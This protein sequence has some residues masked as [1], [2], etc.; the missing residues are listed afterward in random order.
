MAPAGQLWST[1]AD[2]CRFGCFLADPAE[3][4]LS[5][6]S[7]EEMAT[8]ATLE[9]DAWGDGQGHGLQLWRNGERLYAG[10]GGS[11]P[12]F[13]AG[14]VVHRPSRTAATVMA[15]RW[16]GVRGWGLALELLDHV[17]DGLPAPAAPWSAAPAPPPFADLLGHWWWRGVAH[18]VVARDGMLALA[19]VGDDPR[20][21]TLFRQTGPDSYEGT[22]GQDLGEALTV[23]RDAGGTA[24]ALVA[25]G[26]LYTRDP[27]DPRTV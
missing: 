6:A 17:L 12:G 15:N 19:R 11:M 3:E 16:Q 4:V 27:D 18:D 2:L 13:I 9:P 24:T 7:A 10:H 23:Q 21:A 22:N 14:L 25:G 8:P 26:W 20:W 5:A 1:P